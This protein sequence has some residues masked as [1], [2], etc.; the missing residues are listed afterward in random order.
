MSE[1]EVRA[2][3]VNREGPAIRWAKDV[4][5]E[6]RDVLEPI[7]EAWYALVP[8]WVQEF[9]VMWRG[10]DNGA[11]L[12]A[13]V[14]YRNRWAF[15]YVGPSFLGEPVDERE[16]AVLHEL[17]HVLTEPLSVVAERIADM[18]PD[19]ERKAVAGFLEDA[20]EATVEDIARSLRRARER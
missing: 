15:L 2:R 11:A 7:L 18:L 9:R 16:V 6:Y 5:D 17:C 14:N 12:G 1:A 10:D 8:T 4:P 20:L 13:K 19:Y 3:D